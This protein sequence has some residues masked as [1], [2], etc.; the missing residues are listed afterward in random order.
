MPIALAALTAVGVLG[1]G[2]GWIFGSG[3]LGLDGTVHSKELQE[4]VALAA[5]VRGLCHTPLLGYE[6]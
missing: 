1:D 6:H 3:R 5:V 4:P 2:L